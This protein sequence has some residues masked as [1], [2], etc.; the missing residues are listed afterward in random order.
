MSKRKYGSDWKRIRDRY[1]KQQPNCETCIMKYMRVTKATQVH[2]IVPVS[3][4]G[5]NIDANLIALCPDCHKWYHQ[6]MEGKRK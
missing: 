4:G 5:K 1:I 2:H 6:Q 3:Q